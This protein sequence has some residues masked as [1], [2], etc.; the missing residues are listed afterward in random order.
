MHES[1]PVFTKYTPIRLAIIRI[2]L[3]DDLNDRPQKIKT[4]NN[5]RSYKKG[6]SLS[7]LLENLSTHH[8]HTICKK[9]LSWDGKINSVIFR[10]LQSG[11]QKHLNPSGA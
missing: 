4:I 6:S 8:K 5:Q 10:L 11:I 3:G 7:F 9:R 2:H 1:R